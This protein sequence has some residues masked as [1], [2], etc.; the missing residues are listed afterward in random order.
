MAPIVSDDHPHVLIFPPLLAAGAVA[1]GLALQ[2]LVPIGAAWG[3]PWRGLGVL[4]MLAAA[5]LAVWCERTF[6]RHGTNVRPDRPALRLVESGPY[7]FT[8]NPMYV[9][10]VAFQLGLGL[11]LLNLWLL[12]LTIPVALVLDL[13]VMRRE[14]RYLE[15]KFGQPYTS[16]RARVRRWL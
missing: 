3:G 11:A 1:L 16:Y 6:K 13:G 15:T 12:L 4:M 10:L 9:G 14:E 7:R 2:H 5:A 8:R